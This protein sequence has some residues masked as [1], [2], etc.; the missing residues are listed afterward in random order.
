MDSQSLHCEAEH[1]P[2]Q[3]CS[4]LFLLTTHL[5]PLRAPPSPCFA[6]LC[7]NPP[8]ARPGRQRRIRQHAQPPGLP[9]AQPQRGGEPVPCLALQPTANLLRADVGRQRA[10]LADRVGQGRQRRGRGRGWGRVAGAPE[11]AVGCAGGRDG[12][13]AR[14]EVSVCAC[15]RRSFRRAGATGMRLEARFRVVPKVPKVRSG[16]VAAVLPAPVASLQPAPLVLP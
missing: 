9:P 2:W 11:L 7:F 12:A 4:A 10:A 5:S 3:R 15:T 13:A 14:F 16:S 6:L 8:T 1:P